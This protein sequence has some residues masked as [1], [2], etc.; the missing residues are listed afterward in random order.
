MGEKCTLVILEREPCETDYLDSACEYLLPE[1]DYVFITG[2]TLT[3][4]TL[5]RLLT[6]TQKARTIMVG[7]SVPITPLM[8][9]F[10]ADSLA[11]FYVTDCEKARFLTAQAA[12]TEI[13]RSGNRVTFSR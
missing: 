13:F 1:Q 10:G 7:P 11:G 9:R 12:H 5:P 3:N 4:K 8:F 2:M 6:L